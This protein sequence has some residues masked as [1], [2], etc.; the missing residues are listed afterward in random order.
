MSL[1]IVCFIFANNFNSFSLKLGTLNVKSFLGCCK[2]SW[3][4]IHVW[5]RKLSNSWRDLKMIK[6]LEE[7]SWI[8]A[9]DG[10]SSSEE[11][12]ILTI[13]KN[14][15]RSN[16]RTKVPWTTS[17]ERARNIHWPPF[18][19]YGGDQRL[20]ESIHLG[21]PNKTWDRGAF[22]MPINKPCMHSRG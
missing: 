3:V 22:N 15:S 20:M 8:L 2:N 14:L 11:E 17:I 10:I 21:A 5:N 7:L 1:G 18:P 12:Q 4:L 6:S 19:I 16:R 13:V 9:V